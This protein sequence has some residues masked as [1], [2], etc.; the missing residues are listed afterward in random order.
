MAVVRFYTDEANL[1]RMGGRAGI[2]R[3]TTQIT[4]LR[5]RPEYL[6]YDFSRI[7]VGDQ[8]YANGQ[9]QFKFVL[10]RKGDGFLRIFT[11]EGCIIAQVAVQGRKIEQDLIFHHYHDD[12]DHRVCSVRQMVKGKLQGLMLDYDQDDNNRLI[13]MS[14]FDRKGFSLVPMVYFDPDGT[15]EAISVSCNY[16]HEL[17]YVLKPEFVQRFIEKTPENELLQIFLQHLV[18]EHGGS[19]LDYLTVDN[20]LKPQWRADF[21]DSVALFLNQYSREVHP[22]LEA[23]FLE[24][25]AGEKERRAQGIATSF[26]MVLDAIPQLKN[27]NS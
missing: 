26:D 21:G 12:L 25:C 13:C 6:S 16:D 2:R 5:A 8:F 1:A 9:C 15:M 3:L 19:E 20:E 11:P 4:E 27:L 24:F 14:I 17:K 23:P 10:N 7:K 18:H 22:E